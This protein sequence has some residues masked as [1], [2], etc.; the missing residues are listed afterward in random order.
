MSIIGVD[1][2]P[3]FQEIAAVDTESP[4][5]AF[6]TPPGKQNSSIVPWHLWVRRYASACRPVGGGW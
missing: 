2:H 4:R 6:S 5:K 3:D 1:F